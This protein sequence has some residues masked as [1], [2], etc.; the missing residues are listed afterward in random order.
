MQK[1][2]LHIPDYDALLENCTSD[3]DIFEALSQCQDNRVKEFYDFCKNNSYNYKKKGEMVLDVIEGEFPD[4]QEYYKIQLLHAEIYKNKSE[5]ISDNVEKGILKKISEEYFRDAEQSQ[6]DC[7]D[8]YHTK[9]QINYNNKN[10]N[11]TNCNKG[12]ERT[13][14]PNFLIIK[15]NIQSEFNKEDSIETLKFGIDNHPRENKLKNNLANTLCFM[16]R[17]D[18]AENYF[19]QI[20][21]GLKQKPINA[22]FYNNLGGFNIILKNYEKSMQYLNISNKLEKNFITLFNLATINKLVDNYTES[23]KFY[24]KASSAYNEFSKN[25][26]LRKD[27]KNIPFPDLIKIANVFDEKPIQDKI[28]EINKEDDFVSIKDKFEKDVGILL[29]DIQNLNDVMFQKLV[30]HIQ[31]RKDG[32]L[33]IAKDISDLRK[34][35]NVLNMTYRWINQKFGNKIQDLFSTLEMIRVITILIQIVNFSIIKVSENLHYYKLKIQSPIKVENCKKIV[36]DLGIFEEY[37]VKNINI[38]NL[39]SQSFEFE[40]K[41]EKKFYQ[42][43]DR[44][45]IKEISEE[46]LE[47]DPKNTRALEMK[48]FSA[49]ESNEFQMCAKTAEELAIILPKNKYLFLCDENIN[50]TL[51]Q[52]GN[53]PSKVDYTV[54]M[55]QN[56]YDFTT[57]IF[58]NQISDVANLAINKNNISFF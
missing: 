13:K 55:L 53:D 23:K 15:S 32:G 35:I 20:E 4:I 1:P 8:Y 37:T 48:I 6:N 7:P 9:T 40:H 43:T 38:F 56:I 12:Y 22:V 36:N 47:N 21:E 14:D 24:K 44:K 39:D 54:G 49:F 50:Q 42:T 45:K 57:N 3:H 46:I 2:F 51:N 41:S 31:E 17:F 16:K 58:S 18:E 11:I 5:K 26:G 52:Y 19:Y 29:N 34:S 27:E 10:E 33:F 25:Y 28:S 30:H